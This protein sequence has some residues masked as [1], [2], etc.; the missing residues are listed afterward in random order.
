[1]K[2]RNP[3]IINATQL[4]HSG[5][6]QPFIAISHPKTARARCPRATRQKIVPATVMKVF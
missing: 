4:I 5:A 3:V 1:V 6:D 2:E